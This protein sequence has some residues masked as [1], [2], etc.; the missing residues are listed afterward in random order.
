MILEVE[1]ALP[2]QV[3]QILVAQA[4]LVQHP[5]TPVQN[6]ENPAFSRHHITVPSQSVQVLYPPTPGAAAHAYWNWRRTQ[7]S[8][9]KLNLEK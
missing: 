8:C 4:E 9:G 7:T 1:G 6:R 3:E 2:Y 5:G